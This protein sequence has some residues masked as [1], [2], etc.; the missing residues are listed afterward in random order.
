M[1]DTV[2]R[3]AARPVLGIGFLVLAVACFAVLDTTV[4]YVGLVMPVLV[5]GGFALSLIHI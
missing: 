5:A 4:K 2:R 1:A 3:A